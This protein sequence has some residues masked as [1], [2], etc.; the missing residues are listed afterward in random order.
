[1]KSCETNVMI[2]GT[3]TIAAPRTYRAWTR[4]DQE[5][6]EI[7]T[8][9]AEAAKSRFSRGRLIK[10]KEDPFRT[11][12]QRDVDRTAYSESFMKLAGRTQ[13]Q[14]EPRMSFDTTRL[15]HTD[16]V[17][18]LSRMITRALNLNQDL[19][20]G[21]AKPHDLGTPP[22]GHAGEKALDSLCHTHSEKH[23]RHNIHS[24]RILDELEPYPPKALPHRNLTYEVREGV[25]CHLKV[26]EELILKPYGTRRD[27][28]PRDLELK[29]LK[30]EMEGIDWI[31]GRRFYPSTYEGLVVMFADEIASY[32]VDFEDGI[33]RGI[34]RRS[35]L[36]EKVR[37]RLGN[38][39]SDMIHQAV[40]SLIE[41]SLDKRHKRLKGIGMDEHISEAMKELFHFNLE[42]IYHRKELAPFLEITVPRKI[43]QLYNFLTKS[44]KLSHQEAIDNIASLRDVDALDLYST[45]SILYRIFSIR[46]P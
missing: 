29:E 45:S 9:F 15:Y 1:M 32:P 27:E 4:V 12:Y 23:F 16:K 24:L 40:I 25:I 42:K 11:C 3:T 8:L 38:N 26:A 39:V 5:Q 7:D 36:P 14:P 31:E 46:R 21:I 10:E 19:A 37:K 6:W 18:H 22:F 35:Q 34:I 44:K 28:P 20:E 33:K 43:S 41:T 17:V 30:K 13:V 2:R